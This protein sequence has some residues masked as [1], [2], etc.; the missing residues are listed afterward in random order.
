MKRQGAFLLKKKKVAL[1]FFVPFYCLP[2]VVLHSLFLGGGLSLFQLA[3]IYL[4]HVNDTSKF[5]SFTCHWN[6]KI[7]AA[8]IYVAHSMALFR[9]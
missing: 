2:R 9:L 7:E 4:K 1:V 6:E 3:F 5:I 8:C